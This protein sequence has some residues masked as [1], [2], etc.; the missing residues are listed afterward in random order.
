M[1][2][3]YASDLHLEFEA[4]SRYLRKNPIV[5]TG[6]ILLLAGDIGVLGEDYMKYPSGIGLLNTSSKLWS[7]PET[8]SSTRA[9]ILLHSIQE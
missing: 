9:K 1:K 4:N 6:D 7:F 2:I 8:M 5:P 3:Q